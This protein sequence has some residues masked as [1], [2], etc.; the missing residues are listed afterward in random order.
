M[1]KII[2][3]AIAVMLC[4]FAN[5]Q[6]VKVG[7]KGSLNLSSWAGDTRGLNLRPMFGVNIGA[8]TQIKLSDK[9]DIQPEVLYSNQVTKMKNAGVNISDIYYT[10]DIKWNLSY[11]NVP[12][13][14]KYSA[15][16]KSFIE[17]GPQ[18]GFLTS[19]KTSA[20]LTQYSPIVKEDVKEAFEFIDFGFVIGVGYNIN[21]HL[22]ADLR[23]NIGLSNIAKTESG[24]DTKIRNS[25]L[26]LSLAYK[27]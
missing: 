20:K 26:A 6:D 16:D 12:V 13:L 2:L 10:G 15:D 17:A 1:K 25:V 18:V 4:G 8:L 21:Q 9:F 11:V 3:S 27:F 5:A 14:F 22:M 19:A 24:D 23:Y 7:I